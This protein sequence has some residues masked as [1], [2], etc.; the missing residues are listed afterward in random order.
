[1]DSLRIGVLHYH[2]IKGGVCTVIANA[3]Q[4]LI[5][6]GGFQNLEIDLIT[7]DAREKTGDSMAHDLI[8]WAHDQGPSEFTLNQIQ[9]PELGYSQESAADRTDLYDRAR[10]ISDIVLKAI[11]PV[12]SSPDNPYVLHV[13]NAN[14]GKNPF[15]TLALKLLLEKLDQEN[16]PAWILYQMHDF[17]E[18]NRVACWRTLK[19]CS[20]T[21]DPDL[22]VEMM[23]PTSKKKR[24]QWACINSADRDHL[25]SIG[26]D[27][28]IIT[29]VPN[30]VAV[31]D[32]AS[33]PL[34]CMSTSSLRKLN[35][36][37]IDF[38]SD[39]KN[40]IADFSRQNGFYFYPERKILLYPVKAIRRKNIAESIVL[41]MALNN[42]ND[43]YQL[44]VTLPPNSPDDMDY[45]RRL[46]QFVKEHHLPVVIGFG[47]RLLQKGDQRTVSDGNVVS[48]SL[49]DMM[50]LSSAVVTTSFQE[51]FG[52]V[53]H[54]P[55]VAGKFVIGR[56]IPRITRDF[57][58]QG[59]KLDHLYDH[60]LIPLEWLDSKWQQICQEYHRKIITMH[61]SLGLN[62]N[63]NLQQLTDIIPQ[64]KTYQ[65]NIDNADPENTTDWAD[66]NLDAQLY[67]LNT[68]TNKPSLLNRIRWTNSA[69]QPIKHWF[70][71]DLSAIIKNNRNMVHSK[72]NLKNQAS[73][74]VSL[75][76][77]GSRAIGRIDKQSP[78]RPLSNEPILKQSL[79]VENVRLLA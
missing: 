44:C 3:L 16:L 14:L 67:I 52:Y 45:C 19:E 53:F 24:I 23:Y 72:Y 41:M 31:D 79:Q 64:T 59:F 43:E 65:I 29:I 35:I 50:A 9:I 76:A 2:L 70:P 32:F 78:V 71:P 58:Q 74:L 12:R 77:R 75:L 13:H 40:K 55:W 38:V 56:N 11:N 51:G 47:T 49:V 27:P 68:L 42:Q 28:E 22:A 34:S 62:P 66:L 20:G 46:E 37:P 30:A 25:L 4:A 5:A 39:I 15:L 63:F 54:E 61:Q 33:E 7:S 36:K 26:I 1:M 18:I 48:Y 21:N 8:E 6:H 10:R 69:L 17:A 57:T 73:V 60:M